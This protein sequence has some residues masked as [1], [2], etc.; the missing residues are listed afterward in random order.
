MAPLTTSIEIA[1]S[2]AEV[3]SY[4]TDPSKF[5]EWQDGVVDGS[6]EGGREPVVGSKCL[7][8]RRIGGRERRV[9]SEITKLD[10]PTSWSV[11]GID[12]PIRATVDVTVEPVNESARSRVTIALDF[13]AHGIGKLLVPLIVRRQARDEMPVNVDCLKKRLEAL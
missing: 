9:T 3:F 1:Q 8:T 2:Q 11:R 13:E 4:V 6:V 5:S 7:T 12:G 10:P